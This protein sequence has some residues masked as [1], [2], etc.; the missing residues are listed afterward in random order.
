MARDLIADD[1]RASLVPFLAPKSV[2][3]KAQ[4]HR[5]RRVAV[6]AMVM[7]V[8]TTDASCSQSRARR[9]H[10][11]IQANVRSTTHPLPGSGFQANHER[12]RRMTTK[13][14]IHD[15]RLTISSVTFVLS[16]AHLTRRP[17]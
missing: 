8:S 6:A 5:L 1:A 16:F 9:R 13:P 15:M 12:G 10:F 14:F 2:F 3:E 4:G 17:A 7:R 11:M